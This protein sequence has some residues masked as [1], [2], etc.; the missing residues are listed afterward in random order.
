MHNISSVPKAEGRLP[1]CLRPESLGGCGPQRPKWANMGQKRLKNR[2]NPFHTHWVKRAF[3]EG[4]RADRTFWAMRDLWPVLGYLNWGMLPTLVQ[5]P[6]FGH[7]VG[8]GAMVVSKRANFS[9]WEQRWPNVGFGPPLGAWCWGLVSQGA[10]HFF[11]FRDH[12]RT[13]VERLPDAEG[14]KYKRTNNQ[15]GVGLAK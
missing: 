1:C 12:N 14:C 15:Q 7:I 2:V 5:R 10:L 6:G 8:Y 4:E 11:A 13:G 9:K 3:F